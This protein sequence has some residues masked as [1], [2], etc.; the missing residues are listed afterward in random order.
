MGTYMKP[1][2]KWSS[3]RTLMMAFQTNPT[4]MLWWL[5]FIAFPANESC[6]RQEENCEQVKDQVFVEI[7][8]TTSCPQGTL[9]IYF[10]TKLL[11]TKMSSETLF[12]NTR[13]DKRTRSSSRRDTRPARTNGSSRSWGFRSVL[14]RSFK[15][16]NKNQQAPFLVYWI[17]LWNCGAQ[18]SWL[19]FKLSRWARC[20]QPV[21]GSPWTQPKASTS[22]LFTCHSFCLK[23]SSLK[24]V[25]FLS[26]S[27]M[28]LHKCYFSKKIFPPT[29][30][31]YSFLPTTVP[32]LNMI[33]SPM[34]FLTVTWLVI[35]LP[36]WSV[37]SVGGWP[38]FVHHYIPAVLEWCLVHNWHLVNPFWIH[39]WM[40]WMNE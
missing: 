2:V 39:K 35:P 31:E 5:E 9:W 13:P 16:K 17:R 8:M 20:I 27:F 22:G 38:G 3:W 33:L 14:F 24:C 30:M 12:S 23:S 37:N 29:P 7:Y 32:P 34:T 11:L 10:W 26:S 40:D 19:V 15:K 18:K 36:H 21:L 4:A 25:F 28:S 6:H 1:D